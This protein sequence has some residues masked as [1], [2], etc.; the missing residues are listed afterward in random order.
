MVLISSGILI[1]VNNF[2][3]KPNFDNF[4]Q[5]LTYNCEQYI[6]VS[7]D[8]NFS[9]VYLTCGYNNLSTIFYNTKMNSYLTN[10]LETKNRN[11]FYTQVFQCVAYITHKSMK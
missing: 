10:Q 1:I 9:S 11:L 7:F 4:F 2:A 3:S 6:S 5:C 8:I